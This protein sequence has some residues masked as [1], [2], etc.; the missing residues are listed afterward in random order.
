VRRRQG[1]VNAV[2]NLVQLGAQTNARA[3]DGSSLLNLSV[4]LSDREVAQVLRH[5]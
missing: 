1:R 2:K 5:S 4:R 3:A